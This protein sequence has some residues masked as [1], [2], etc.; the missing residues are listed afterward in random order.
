MRMTAPEAGVLPPLDSIDLYDPERYRSTSQHPA[1]AAL[2]QAGTPWPQHTPAGDR[3]WSVTNYRDVVTVLTDD[4]NYSSEHGTILAVAAGDS[5][6]GKTI[7]LMDQP[8]HARVRLPT[9]RTMSTRVVRERKEI[10]RGHVR[11]LIGDTFTG[12]VKIDV[13]QLMLQL[14]MAAIGEI[15]GVPQEIWPDLPRWAMAGVAPGDPGYA[16]TSEAATLSSAHY[17]LFSTF[18]ELIQQR[19]QRRRDD[20]IS[21]LLDLDFGGRHLN[22]NELV[23]NCYSFAMGAITTTPHV[24]SHLLLALIENPTAWQT[25]RANPA[26]VPTAVEEALRW[27][28]PTNHLLRRTLAPVRIGETNLDE[29]ELVCAWV[30]SANRDPSVFADPYV[31]DPARDPNPHL[32]FGIGAHRCIGGPAAQVALAVF[33]EEML[34]CLEGFEL[35]GEVKHLCSNFIN[36]ITSLPVIFYP[37]PGAERTR[38]DL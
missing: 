31:F 6:G 33:I 11:R 32:G 25:L 10:V 26:L 15:L 1:W 30:A 3:F 27:A 29:G 17:E 4:R 24:A 13:A 28:S 9:M 21:V 38:D 37:T 5:A 2:R 36:G 23:L 35:A 14:P 34:A 8:D 22:D 19:R 20:V 18:T 12:G 7:N 16:T